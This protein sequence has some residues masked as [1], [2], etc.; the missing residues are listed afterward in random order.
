MEL[1]AIRAVTLGQGKILVG[2]KNGE[3]SFFSLAKSLMELKLVWIFDIFGHEKT[4]KDLVTSLIIT[5]KF[6]E[7]N[8][9]TFKYSDALIWEYQ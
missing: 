3:V 6:A 2:T 4:N 8:F 1:P 7:Q 9:W 5:R